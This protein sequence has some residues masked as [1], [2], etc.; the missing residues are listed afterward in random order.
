M[1]FILTSPLT[2]PFKPSVKPFLSSRRERISGLSVDSKFFLAFQISKL[3]DNITRNPLSM[4]LEK[5]VRTHGLNYWVQG[6]L[7]KEKTTYN[8]IFL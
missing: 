1:Y 2:L 7:L 8:D 4:I 5:V 6:C 3:P